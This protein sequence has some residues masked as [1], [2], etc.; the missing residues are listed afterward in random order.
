MFKKIA[1]KTIALFISACVALSF[2]SS[3][4]A[5]SLEELDEYSAA[6]PDECCN[7]TGGPNCDG[8]NDDQ[9]ADNYYE[10][11]G[12]DCPFGWECS[13]AVCTEDSQQWA[14]EGTDDAD[15]DNGFLNP[16][17][18]SCTIDEETIFCTKWKQ[19]DC[20]TKWRDGSRQLWPDGPWIDTR[21]YW[22][23]ETNIEVLSSNNNSRLTC[24]GDECWW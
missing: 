8:V 5:L 15:C 3:P 12:Y 2:C 1:F 19:S 22:C 11:E 7:L 6:C 17:Q 23:S 10:Y 4:R 16:G 9:C 21:Y 20:E 13:G 14:P 24:S 18:D